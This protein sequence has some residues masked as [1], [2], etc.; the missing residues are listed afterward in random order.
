MSGQATPATNNNVPKITSVRFMVVRAT[1]RPAR[2]RTQIKN[3]RIACPVSSY[4]AGLAVGALESASLGRLA[5][6]RSAKG[7]GV[8]PQKKSAKAASSA[9]LGPA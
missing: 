7:R 8:G 3:T 4:H 6:V 9:S 5:A 2:M 1:R